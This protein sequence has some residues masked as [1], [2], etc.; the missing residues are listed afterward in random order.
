[1][2]KRY[3]IFKGVTVLIIVLIVIKYFLWEETRVREVVSL[4]P[5]DGDHMDHF[6]HLGLCCKIVLVCERTRIIE[7][8]DGS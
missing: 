3:F 7:K 8:R 4:N 2:I 1:M 6:S 5:S